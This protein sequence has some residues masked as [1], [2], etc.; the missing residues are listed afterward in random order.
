MCASKANIPSLACQH[1]C[2]STLS[3]YLNHTRLKAQTNYNL[4]KILLDVGRMYISGG[5]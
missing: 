5:L 1:S 4:D 3:S 2:D